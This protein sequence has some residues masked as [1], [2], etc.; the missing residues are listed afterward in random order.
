M[1]TAGLLS[2]SPSRR[3]A[4]ATRSSP[5]TPT[6]GLA[7]K[8]CAAACSRTSCCCASARFPA[9]TPLRSSCRGIAFADQQTQQLGD[10]SR[11]CLAFDLERAIKSQKHP[12]IALRFDGAH[13][14]QTVIESGRRVWWDHAKLHDHGRNQRQCQIAVR[15]RAAERTFTFGA[16]DVDMDPLPIASAGGE[17]VDAILVECY[18]LGHAQLAARELRGI[19]H[20]ILRRC[21]DSTYARP[22]RSLRRILPPLDFGNESRKRTSFG[23]L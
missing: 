19:C 12:S 16:F 13:L 21:H 8:V 3:R 11:L 15:D 20:G 22:R 14:V 4:D 1:E 7:P 6:S 17:R 10:Q 9:I 2:I 18:P 5:R 23:T